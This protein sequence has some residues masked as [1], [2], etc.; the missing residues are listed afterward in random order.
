[1]P[2]FYK[3][4][5]GKN[6][7]NV[8]VKGPVILAMNHPNAFADPI[9]FTYVTYPVRVRYLARGDAFKPGFSAWFLEQLGVVPIFRIQD[10]GKEGLKKNDEAY[11]RVNR[12]LKRNGKIIVFAEGLCV[13]ERRLRPVKKGVARMV[14][15]AYE[16]LNNDK[17]VVI[18]VGV[19]YSKADKF[20]S[21]L[22]YNI[23]EPIYVKDFIKE[24]HENP[25]RANNN[26][27]KVLEPKMKELI[28]HINNKAYDEVVLQI[29]ELCKKDWL[30]E[31]GFNYK[32]L[33]ED[34]IVTKQITEKVNS[35]ELNNKEALDEFKEKAKIYF[36]EVRKIGLRDWLINPKQNKNVNS[37]HL[38]LRWLLIFSGSP[39]YLLGL[40]GNY[41]PCKLTEKITKKILKGNKE[42]YASISIGTGMILLWTNYILWFALIYHF[43]P[44]ILCPLL[45]CLAFALSGWFN[46]YF[47]FFILKT[48]GMGRAIKNQEAVKTLAAQRKALISLINKF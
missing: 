7:K 46:L 1:M 19:N 45:T 30:K 6:V 11:R 26:F 22:F 18:P 20:R 41:I 14:F 16:Y 3:R 47:H 10:A 5:Q 23:G 8:Q 12:L 42:F 2:V 13:Q 31:Q 28:T 32:K 33:E 15:G 24:F 38:I 25:A 40:T 27:V 48:L 39:I 44:N 34:H 29:E 9:L 17:L 4:I 21:T 37:A 35:A 43:S 36:K